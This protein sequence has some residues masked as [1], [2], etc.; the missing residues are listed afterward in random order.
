MSSKLSHGR[1]RRFCAAVLAS[2][3]LLATAACGSNTSSKADASAS[4]DGSF[5]VSIRHAYGTTKFTQA[6]KRIVTVGWGCSTAP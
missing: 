1:I 5:P 3:A 2:F 4:S 6:P